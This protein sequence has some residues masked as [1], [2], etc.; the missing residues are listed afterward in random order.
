MSKLLFVVHRYAPYPGGSEYNVQRLAEEALRRGHRVTILADTHLGDYRGVRVTSDR[1][2]MREPFDLIIVHGDLSPQKAVLAKAH[3]LRSPV[4]FLLVEP[5]TRDHVLQGMQRASFVGWGTSFDLEHIRH[6]GHATKATRCRYGVPAS[7][8]GRPGFKAAFGIRT[9]R[10]YLSAGGFWPRKGMEELTRAF[11]EARPPDTTL[12]LMGYDLRRGVP[13][14]APGV[15]VVVSAEHQAVLDA[16][17]EADLYVMNSRSEGFGVVL[18]EAMLNRTPWAAR[19]IAGAHDL[20][21]CGTVYATYEDLVRLLAS[22]AADP[23]EVA[24][25]HERVLTNHL[26][27]YAFDDI[28]SLLG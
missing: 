1:R 27:E 13:D 16:M 24:R 8:Q 22:F 14:G 5:K 3:R 6:F 19:D 10:M 20:R 28:E 15:R 2:V 4:L 17:C 9:S 26:I 25:A 12:V 23:V 21:D 11:L 18:L 7:T